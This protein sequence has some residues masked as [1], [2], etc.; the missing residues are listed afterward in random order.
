MAQKNYEHYLQL[1]TDIPGIDPLETPYHDWPE[2]P[3]LV[4]AAIAPGREGRIEVYNT[5]FQSRVEQVQTR[6]YTELFG[7]PLF[8]TDILYERPGYPLKDR[9]PHSRLTPTTYG[10][11]GLNEAIVISL[12]NGGRLLDQYRPERHGIIHATAKNGRPDRKVQY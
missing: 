8:F 12:S 4:Q 2:F 6:L 5:G 3:L 1:A 11:F 10:A 7:D 9:D